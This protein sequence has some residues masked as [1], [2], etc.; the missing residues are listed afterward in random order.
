MCTIGIKETY[1]EASNELDEASQRYWNVKITN[2]ILHNH[3]VVRKIVRNKASEVT[4]H[5]IKKCGKF[6][7]VSVSCSQ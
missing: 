2:F 6:E 7:T 4:V 3:R 1:S 5:E